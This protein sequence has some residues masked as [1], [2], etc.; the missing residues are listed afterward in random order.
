MIPS[1]NLLASVSRV[2]SLSKLGYASNGDI[3]RFCLE[4]S[5]AVSH[6]ADHKNC[7]EIVQQINYLCTIWHKGDVNVE[8]S[9]IGRGGKFLKAS[10]L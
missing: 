1:P 5:R 7:S 10:K 2:K 4:A 8:I 9:E 3:T 6:S